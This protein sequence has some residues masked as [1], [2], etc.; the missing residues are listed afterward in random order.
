MSR[1]ISDYHRLELSIATD[2]NDSRRVMP[3][4]EARHRRILDIGC[5][6]GQTLIGSK[7]DPG[8]LAVGIDLDHAALALGK[9]FSPS[10]Q[11]VEGRGETLPFGNEAFDLVICRV[12]LPYMHIGRA[13]SEFSRVMDAGGNLWL[14]LHPFSMT[15]KELRTNLTHLQVKA[16][17]Y[18]L[19][20]LM[21]GLALNSVGKQWHWPGNSNRY[22][23]WQASAGITR[24]LTAAGFGQIRINRE[25]HFVVT[26]TKQAGLFHCH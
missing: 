24:A 1:E 5:G 3:V 14:V 26:A 11:F 19:W 18:R 12:A 9:Q 10:I 2:P 20:V 13:L 16:S 21:N 17:I 4:V 15:A 7:L 6:A 8:V 25:K 22:E 23:T